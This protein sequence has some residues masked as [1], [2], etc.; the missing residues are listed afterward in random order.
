M[1]EARFD[2]WRRSLDDLHHAELFRFL[3]EAELFLGRGMPS[4]CAVLDNPYVM[5][6]LVKSL[7]HAAQWT[8]S[9]LTLL[10]KSLA[11][12]TIKGLSLSPKLKCDPDFAQL[13]TAA[14]GSE[15]FAGNNPHGPAVEAELKQLLGDVAIQTT[16]DEREWRLLRVFYIVRNS[17][18]HQIE[19]SLSFHHDRPFLLQLLQAVFIAYFVIEKRKKGAA[20]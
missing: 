17:T 8:E 3:Y 16:D 4:Y 5:L 12:G 6:R 10:Q 2:A 20:P 9:I 19:D 15:Q 14:G 18:A 13:V 1:T 11:A 7:A